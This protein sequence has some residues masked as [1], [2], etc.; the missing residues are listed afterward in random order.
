MDEGVLEPQQVVVV[1]L[2]KLRIELLRSVSAAHSCDTYHR[3]RPAARTKIKLEGENKR[4]A[5]GGGERTKSSTETSII[6][7]LK[8]AVRF[9]MTL[10][11]TTSCVFR[12]WHLTTWP[13]VPWP[14]TSRMR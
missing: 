12:F 5:P 6:L 14:R 9:L 11:A 2:V 3:K 13:N 4:D 7:W 10:T 1:V 8:Y